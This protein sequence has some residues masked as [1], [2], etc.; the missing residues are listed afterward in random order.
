[1]WSY[2]FDYDT[3]YKDI[4]RNHGKMAN[5]AIP[6]GMFG[7][8][9]SIAQPKQNV[10]LAVQ[11]LKASNHSDG[12]SMTL[13]FNTG[14]TVREKGANLLAQG[15]SDLVKM[16]NADFPYIWLT[17]AANYHVER[18]WVHGYY[19]NPMHNGGPTIGDFTAIS[20]S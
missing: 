11:E 5:G 9:D 15:Y 7:Y 13:F 10:D 19:Y 17:Q 16:S 3:Y 6:K 4:A 1:A 20:K 2:A 12:F 8:D 18:N 14:N